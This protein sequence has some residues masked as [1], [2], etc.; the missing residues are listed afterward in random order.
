MAIQ[1]PQTQVR[2]Y[3]DEQGKL[4]ARWTYDRAKQPNGP[5]LVENFDLPRKEKKVKEVAKKI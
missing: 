1:L 5:I 4:Q 3:F 2:E